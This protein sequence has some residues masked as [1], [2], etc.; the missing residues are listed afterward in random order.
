MVSP[1]GCQDIAGIGLLHLPRKHRRGGLR[2]PLHASQVGT[3]VMDLSQD[4]GQLLL[5]LLFLKN[6]DLMIA[7]SYF[8]YCC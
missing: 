8:R 4:V 5:G 1:L 6:V 2:F 3:K 7:R